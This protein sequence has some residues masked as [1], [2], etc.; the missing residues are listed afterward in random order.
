MRDPESRLE[1][2]NSAWATY[3]H[4]KESKELYLPNSCD[5]DFLTGIFG[6]LPNLKSIEVTLTTC[7]FQKD[8]HHELLGEIWRI[9]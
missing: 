7:P 3:G 8:G 5:L 9:P 2:Q 4:L 6:G 1:A